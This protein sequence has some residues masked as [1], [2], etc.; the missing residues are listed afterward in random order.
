MVDQPQIVVPGGQSGAPRLLP[1]GDGLLEQRHALLELALQQRQK[2]AD[3]NTLPKA[4]VR[5]QKLKYAANSSST[6]PTA[7]VRRGVLEKN[8]SVL[9]ND[10]VLEGA[11][12]I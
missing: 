10:S 12:S 11:S 7:Q 1:H 3:S 5:C 8:D 6:L 2:V 9:A 4:Q